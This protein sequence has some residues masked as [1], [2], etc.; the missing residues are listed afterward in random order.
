M[1]ERKELIQRAKDLFDFVNDFYNPEAKCN[2]FITIKEADKEF[3]EIGIKLNMS[4]EDLIY[5]LNFEELN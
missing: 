2:Q 3:K 4:F 5:K 1:K